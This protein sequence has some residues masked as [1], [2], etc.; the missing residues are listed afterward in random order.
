M[1]RLSISARRETVTLTPHL[2]ASTQLPPSLYEL[3]ISPLRTFYA[4][5]H[6]LEPLQLNAV[7][8]TAMTR[9][10]ETDHVGLLDD[11]GD[12]HVFRARR[13]LRLCLRAAEVKT[14]TFETILLLAVS[15][16]LFVYLIYALLRP[17]KF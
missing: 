6:E 13:R 17:E 1:G 14:M 7:F 2:D 4:Q 11:C 15:I 5:R 9:Q 8:M 10:G 12:D 16:L 3:L